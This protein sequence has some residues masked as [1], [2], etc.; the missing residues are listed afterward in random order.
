M[1]ITIFNLLNT[2]IIVVTRDRINDQIIYCIYVG[3][4]QF[5]FLELH[6]IVLQLHLVTVLW[7]LKSILTSKVDP[8]VIGIK[9]QIFIW[10]RILRYVSV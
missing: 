3:S 2:E 5:V 8:R 10:Q 1:P 4:S 6:R 9:V 7:C